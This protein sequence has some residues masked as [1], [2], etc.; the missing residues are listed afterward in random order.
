M[1]LS[2]FQARGNFKA[3]GSTAGTAATLIMA[4]DDL[5]SSY[6]A[7][8]SLAVVNQ[9][10]AT[11]R[12]CHKTLKGVGEAVWPPNL[13]A[14]L[15]AGLHT[16]SD[17]HQVHMKHRSR[18]IGRNR[19]LSNYVNSATGRQ[20]T[21]KQVGSRLQQ[22]K[23]TCRE[24]RILHLIMGGRL[25][26]PRR[27]HRRIRKC[28]LKTSSRKLV[29]SSPRQRDG[30]GCIFPPQHA[31]L[32]DTPEPISTS[33]TSASPVPESLNQF[34]STHDQ[35]DAVHYDASSQHRSNANEWSGASCAPSPA[36]S[37]HFHQWGSYHP[38][39]Q[40]QHANYDS[41]HY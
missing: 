31:S 12:R 21:P 29:R 16:H 34:S 6:T 35:C 2:T 22:L 4:I 26:S 37:A 41:W 30:T 8:E 18:F 38:A 7:E 25:L 33:A 32:A 1:H 27:D 15:I 19:F 10:D 36:Y 28:K 13:E 5:S 9:Q 20:R 39:V 14:A 40:H 3:S 24:L 17:L 11:G 23:D